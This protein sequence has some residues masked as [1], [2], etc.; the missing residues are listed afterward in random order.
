MTGAR[1]RVPLVAALAMLLAG[2]VGATLSARPQQGATPQ[3]PSPLDSLSGPREGR[4]YTGHPV[5]MEF[6]SADLRAVLTTFSEISALNMVIDPQV[7][8]TVTVRL[9]DVPWDQALEIILRANKL[10]Y[11]VDGNV[12]RVAPLASLADEEM[13]RRKL[14]DEQALAGDLRVLTKTLSYAKA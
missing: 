10:G 7:Q 4:R 11:I 1:R 5:S 9:T 2:P 8:G 12:L 6:D 3:A 14:A 13:Q